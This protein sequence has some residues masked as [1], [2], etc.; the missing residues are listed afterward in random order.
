MN[1]ASPLITIIIAVYNGAHTLQRALDSVFSQNFTSFEL[2]VMDGGSTDGTVDILESNASRIAYWESQPDKGIYDAWNKAISHSLGKWVLF[3]GSDDAFADADAL[4][5]MAA[6]T[7][8][9]LDF[10]Y[11]QLQLVSLKGEFLGIAGGP[12]SYQKLMRGMCVAHS[13]SLHRRGLFEEMGL[14]DTSYR[15]AGDYEF[16]LRVGPKARCAFLKRPILLF[17]MGGV[18]NRRTHRTQLEKLRFQIHYFGIGRAIANYLGDYAEAA[19]NKLLRLFPNRR[20]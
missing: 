6:L 7:S 12:W 3:L 20:S 8:P 2:V 5:D 17:S 18:S 13:G 15:I 4:G 14:F 19:W 16:I 1:T 11:A 10:V 9:E